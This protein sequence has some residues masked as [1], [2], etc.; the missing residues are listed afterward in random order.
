M[1]ILT[2]NFI[3]LCNNYYFLSNYKQHEKPHFSCWNNKNKTSFW[4]ALPPDPPPPH[5]KQSSIH[6]YALLLTVH[7]S[8]WTICL[9]LHSNVFIPWLKFSW[10]WKNKSES[11]YFFTL[12]SN[13]SVSGTIFEKYH[14][15]SVGFIVVTT[16]HILFF[17]N[18]IC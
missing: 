14:K 18:K 5:P 11:R 4:G 8:L 12:L 16:R 13:L 1:K 2:K 6:V 7:H 10:Y 17:L 9:S 3:S 15:K